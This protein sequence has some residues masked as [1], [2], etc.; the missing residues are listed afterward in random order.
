MNE[1]CA[2]LIF[3]IVLAIIGVVLLI[4]FMW[5]EVC[6]NRT[7]NQKLK[8][9]DEIYR[10]LYTHNREVY[11][12]Q[13]DAVSYQRHMNA[14]IIGRDPLKLYGKELQELMEGKL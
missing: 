13:F 14:L 6:N 4:Y 8:M 10:E 5:A 2:A 3:P 9:L 11:K 7:K 12:S 1:V